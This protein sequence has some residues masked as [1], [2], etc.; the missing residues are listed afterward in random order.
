[1]LKLERIISRTFYVLAAKPPPHLAG[2]KTFL[3]ILR[4]MK[5]W[6]ELNWFSLYILVFSFFKKKCYHFLKIIFQ[7]SSKLLISLFV[8]SRCFWICHHSVTRLVAAGALI[9][10]STWIEGFKELKSHVSPRAHS[11]AVRASMGAA[12]SP[13]RWEQSELLVHVIN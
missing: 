5:D 6:R 3:L 2:S 9:K 4:R 10:E 8:A 7:I 12:H 11:D 1:M 13:P